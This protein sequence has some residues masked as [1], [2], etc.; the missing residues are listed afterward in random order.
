MRY[1]ACEL[2]SQLLQDLLKIWHNLC[3]F[4]INIQHIYGDQ[5]FETIYNP[6]NDEQ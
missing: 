3:G 4:N 1:A 2:I 6:F 5:V